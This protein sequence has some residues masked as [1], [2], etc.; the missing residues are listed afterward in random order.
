VDEVL[1]VGD[2][3]F[4]QKC[5]G[6]MQGVAS[7][8]GRT[9]LFVSHNMAAIQQLCGQAMWLD[10]GNLRDVGS[11]TH[12]V[13]AYA[14]NIRVDAR[15]GDL[16]T[17]R[18]TGDGQVMLLSYRVTDENGRST[19]PPGTRQ[20]VLIHV[21]VRARNRILKPAYGISIVNER[22]IL[23]TCIN[24]VELG[25]TLPELPEGE[26]T[27]C[28]RIKETNFL[29]GIYDASFWVMNPQTHIY[30]MSENGIHFEVAQAP[31]YGTCHVDHR[32]GLVYSDILF[33]AAPAVVP[34]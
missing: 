27:I 22:G 23:M 3:E 1:A 34:V 13:N 15:N 26:S 11:V 17:S 10:H 4:Q 30:A 6:K 25:A 16:S 29:P 12:V 19:P 33:T 32:W 31:I 7:G 21:R 2:A 20:D 24:T 5:L 18:L 14:N 8:E 9:V 28:V